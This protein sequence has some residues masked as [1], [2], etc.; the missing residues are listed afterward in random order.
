MCLF[1]NY[2]VK[3]TRKVKK[4]FLHVSVM[5]HRSIFKPLSF[6]KSYLERLF[7][8]NLYHDSNILHVDSRFF[9]LEICFD[10][11][12]PEMIS[13]HFHVFYYTNK[14]FFPN[15]NHFVFRPNINACIYTTFV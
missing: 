3:S 12:Y 8:L 10:S 15:P 9:S 1:I 13:C 6:V 4:N 14:E 7:S 11:I 5:P 2:S